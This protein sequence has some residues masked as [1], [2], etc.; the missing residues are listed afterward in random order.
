MKTTIT[1][2]ITAFILL[3]STILLGQ[4]PHQLQK[5][6]EG[7]VDY[8]DIDTPEDLI[9]LG[10]TVSLDADNDGTPDFGGIGDKMLGNYRLAADI[11][12]DPDSSKVDWNN[13]GIV[14]F[15]NSADSYGWYPIGT[16]SDA[17]GDDQRFGGTFDGQYHTISN[18]YCSFHENKTAMFANLEGATIENLRILNY[19][20][21]QQG[22]IASALVGRATYTTED[23]RDVIRRVWVEAT[24]YGLSTLMDGDAL[25]NNLYVGGIAGRAGFAD[26]SECVSFVTAHAATE[27]QRRVGGIV[28]QHETSTTIKNCYTVS[29]ITA[30]EEAGGILGRTNGETAEAAIENCY[31]VGL[32]DGTEVG[33]FAGS[34]GAIAITSSYWDNEKYGDDVGVFSG[35]NAANVVG[36][37][38]ADFAVEAKFVGWD[39][40]STWK[41][42]TVDGETRPYLQW[43]DLVGGG[44]G[45]NVKNPVSIGFTAY[46][47]PVSGKLTI[48]NAPLNA[49]YRMMNMIG[50]TVESG[51]V[52]SHRMMLNVENYEKGIYLLKVGDNVNK[53]L[54]K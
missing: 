31:T 13:D 2:L 11:T 44:S 40:T 35:D 5:V 17:M 15:A 41:M 54:V 46:P 27:V 37:T 12:F 24:F 7:S 26:I 14:D 30:Y 20:A 25:E 47:N 39:F 4:T 18:M 45:T 10:D 3:G 34:T 53:I 50:Q 38:T 43:Q 36:L 6:T 16:W 32:V 29:K 48:E 42:G 9:W 19:R 22:A 1:L 8:W 28:G 33:N 23:N 49:E 21:L 52:K 51:V